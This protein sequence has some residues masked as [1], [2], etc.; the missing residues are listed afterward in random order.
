MRMEGLVKIMAIVRPASGLKLSSRSWKHF[1][2]CGP[3][4]RASRPA[5]RSGAVT[6][7]SEAL[8]GA[9]RGGCHRY[10]RSRGVGCGGGGA[11]MSSCQC[12][13]GERT[14]AA[15]VSIARISSV[16][17]SSMCRKWCP[18]LGG[19]TSLPLYKTPA[20][21]MMHCLD[22]QLPVRA[23]VLLGKARPEKRVRLPTEGHGAC[24]LLIDCL[25][26]ELEVATADSAQPKGQK[27]ISH[28]RH[29]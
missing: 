23:E 20:R 11:L 16:L 25:S 29:D 22:R 28:V 7:M 2:T 24:I 3:W 1:F 27:S 19:D 5:A 17:K 10:D 12:C 8:D 9:S 18:L 6:P 13:C 14:F 4:Q 26:I 15:V 21:V